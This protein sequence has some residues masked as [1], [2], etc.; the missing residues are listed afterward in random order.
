[1]IDSSDSSDSSD[2]SYGLPDVSEVGNETRTI[3]IPKLP[4]PGWMV[5][6]LRGKTRLTGGRGEVPDVCVGIFGG[7]RR[8]GVQ[9]R[10]GD[11]VVRRTLNPK[12]VVAVL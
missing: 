6:R 10:R 8:S 12:P 4:L 1:M 7:G 2:P 9:G 11:R 3:L 5:T